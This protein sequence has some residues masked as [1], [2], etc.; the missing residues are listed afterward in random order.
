[1]RNA[2]T[3]TTNRLV[4]AIFAT[5]FLNSLA[6]LSSK[7]G[8]LSNSKVAKTKPDSV[9]AILTEQ[10]T[11][12]LLEEIRKAGIDLSRTNPVSRSPGLCAGETANALV[13]LHEKGSKERQW[14]I[15]LQVLPDR[16]NSM[17]KQTTRPLTIFSST[18]SKF[19][20]FSTN[21]SLNLRTLGPFQTVGGRPKK[22]KSQDLNVDAIINEGFLELGLDRAADAIERTIRTW[23]ARPHFSFSPSPPTASERAK[24]KEL[25]AKVGLLP[26]EERALCAAGPALMSYL[27]LTQNSPGLQE[28]YYALMDWGSI[29]SVVSNGG[30]RDVNLTFQSRR[31]RKANEEDWNLP[32]GVG[33]HYLPVVLELNKR[34]ALEITLVVT[35]PKPPFLISGGIIGLMASKPGDD[36]TLLT[37]RLL[38]NPQSNK[39][40]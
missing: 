22:G 14:I 26:E 36:N 7:G 39:A 21:R 10:M 20:F 37:L 6:L 15:H 25:A 40:K 12:A 34:P 23:A 16:T 3:F 27:T 31:T 29:W 13:T 33:V 38:E 35:S 17:A 8:E 2:G 9:A 4:A 19:E 24:G 1:M 18:G 32:S 11:P 5:I 30:V 28:I